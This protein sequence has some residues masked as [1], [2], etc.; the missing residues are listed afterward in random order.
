M[1]TAPVDAV[2]VG[3]VDN[4]EVQQATVYPESRKK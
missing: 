4:V 2:I 3:I 1:Q